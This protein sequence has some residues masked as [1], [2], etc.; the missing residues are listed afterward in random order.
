MKILAIGH[1]L[2]HYRQKAMWK[3]IAN[4]G[5]KV[6]VVVMRQYRDESYEYEQDG[7]FT[8]HALT[9]YVSS[10]TDTPNFW[11]FPQLYDII[12]DLDPDII[13]CYQ[14]PWTVA[15]YHSMMAANMFRKPFVFFTWEN[16]DRPYPNPERRIQVDSIYNS[17]GIVAGN[18]DAA[19]MMLSKGGELV[20]CGLQTGLDHQ[21]MVPSPKLVMSEQPETRNILFVGR[22]VAEK[23][24]EVILKAFDKLPDNYNLRFV[25]GRGNMGEAIVMHPEFGKRITLEPWVDYS[26]LPE[27]YNWA[28]VSLMP[29]I[30]TEGWREQCGYVVGE[31]LLC[32][33]PV[34]TTFSKSI[35]EWWKLPDV[36]FV[37]QGDVDALADMLMDD[38][39]Y[40]E[41]VEGR[42]AVMEK[43][44]N[45]AVAKNY[46]DLFEELI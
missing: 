5:H 2:G 27:I 19:K 23:G 14:E 15:C 7:S 38:N 26:K 29:S 3:W 42:K 40:H 30:D 44:S 8:Q 39:I 41:A 17:V 4:E 32:H 45:E 28:D 43:Y 20:V 36:H 10:F 22:L 31:S 9:P 46:I 1:S 13:M 25:G 16:I 11:Y 12:K 35:V 21:L 6:D 33:V 18:M 34:I 37:Q 24:I